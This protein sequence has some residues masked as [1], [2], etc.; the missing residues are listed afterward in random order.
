MDVP[1][2]KYNSI[3][4]QKVSLA[5]EGVLYRCDKPAQFHGIRVGSGGPGVHVLAST[6][7][8]TR[9]KTLAAQ[10]SGVRTQTCRICRNPS[11][12]LLSS[13]IFVAEI[14]V[15]TAAPTILL[16]PCQQNRVAGRASRAES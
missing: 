13:E 9:Q 10:S 15:T 6:P 8:G 16:A 5:G 12:H 7:K 14:P 3:D 4:F 1:C 2:P 11:A